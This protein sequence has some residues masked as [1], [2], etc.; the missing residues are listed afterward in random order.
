VSLAS[1]GKNTLKQN[2]SRMDLSLGD[3]DEKLNAPRWEG[4][5]GREV[6]WTSLR[7]QRIGIG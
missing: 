5:G 6:K 3:W 7:V 2:R 4:G 1:H